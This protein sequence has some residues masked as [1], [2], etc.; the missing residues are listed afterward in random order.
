VEVKLKHF[1]RNED[2]KKSR[3]STFA[4][5][6]QKMFWKEQRSPRE[7]GL[8]ICENEAK[9]VSEGTKA[10]K[11]TEAQNLVEAKV[12]ANQV[13]HVSEQIV[14]HN[15]L[16]FPTKIT[17]KTKNLNRCK[18]LPVACKFRNQIQSHI[19][20]QSNVRHKRSHHE[21]YLVTFTNTSRLTQHRGANNTTHNNKAQNHAPM[22]A[23]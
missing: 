22:N 15:T 2:P 11:R 6:K 8:N 19:K 5:A 9:N 7:K 17:K 4:E 20:A 18:K 12:K 23:A 21:M 1:G 3:G 14:I 13:Q 16:K 10:P